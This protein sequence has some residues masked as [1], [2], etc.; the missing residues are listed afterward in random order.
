MKRIM[1]NRLFMI[2][3]A[4]DLLSNFGDVMYYLALMNYILLLPDV[5]W[6]VSLITASELVPQ[7]F[8]F[9]FGYIADKT[10]NKVAGVIGTLI[11]R[12]V[13]Y[14]IVG[15]LMGMSPAT[16][17]LLA[18]IVI[19]FLSDI[20]GKLESGLFVPLSVQIIDNED[21]EIAMSFRE[22]VNSLSGIMFSALSAI[23]VGLMSFQTLAWFNAGTFL[24]CALVMVGLIKPLK[25]IERHIIP[26]E[27]PADAPSVKLWTQLKNVVQLFKGESD[28]FKTVLLLPFLNGIFSGLN[29]FFILLIAKNPDFVIINSQTTLSAAMIILMVGNISGNILGSSLMK[30]MPLLK[31]VKGAIYGAVVLFITMYLQQIY[32]TIIVLFFVGMLAGALSPKFNA[33]ILN[34]L[35]KENLGTAIGGLNSFLQVGILLMLGTLSVLTPL[36]AVEYLILG[37]I[38]LSILL[39]IYV[40]IER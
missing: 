20:S 10:Q 22:T 14:G 21:R 4:T 33:K 5:T 25:Q 13:L 38:V 29:L 31:L 8:G 1:T 9:Y 12:T 28:I 30:E 37:V 16:W 6:G 3:F 27:K 18:I 32:L 40:T 39:A 19:N 7:I 23:L 26:S 34:E 36:V 35:P 11:F 24:V 17:I 2:T 15:F